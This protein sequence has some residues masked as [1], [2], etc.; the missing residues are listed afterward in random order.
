MAINTGGF[1]YQ[2]CERN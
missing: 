2:C 1:S